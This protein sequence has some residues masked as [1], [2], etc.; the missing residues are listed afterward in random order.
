MRLL[1]R[2]SYTIPAATPQQIDAGTLGARRAVIQIRDG[3]GTGEVQITDNAA[4][5]NRRIGEMW[6]GNMDLQAG[7]YMDTP[8]LNEFLT[9]NNGNNVPINA[10]VELYDEPPTR[11]QGNFTSR[12]LSQALT[13]SQDLTE[14]QFHGLGCYP[15]RVFVVSMPL[16]GRLSITIANVSTAPVTSWFVF[17]N[18]G[19][20][21]TVLTQQITFPSSFYQL[22][23]INDDAGA[24]Q[25]M[26]VFDHLWLP[27]Q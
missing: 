14:P 16:A 1:Q 17:Q 26:R 18:P 5:F 19:P 21:A 4:T 7:E 10:H 22:R 23:F 12:I 15:N 2:Q 24:G 8:I 20:G 27:G 9:I 11:P 25:T 6:S 3:N 13:P